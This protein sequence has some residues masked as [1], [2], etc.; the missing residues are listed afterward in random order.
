M[1]HTASVC[2]TGTT[3]STDGSVC[4]T[5]TPSASVSTTGTCSVSPVVASTGTTLYVTGIA[6]SATTARPMPRTMIRGSTMPMA[7]GTSLAGSRA[8]SARLETA[9]R[10]TKAAAARGIAKTRRRPRWGRTQ[11]DLPGDDV[12]LQLREEADGDEQYEGRQPEGSH[13]AAQ[14]HRLSQPGDVEQEQEGDDSDAAHRRVGP[15]LELRPEDAQI[16]RDEGRGDG[17][18]DDAVE[19]KSPGGREPG[20]RPQGAPGEARDP[21]GLGHGGGRLGVGP[22]RDDDHHPDEQQDQ[23]RDAEGVERDAAQDDV[24]GRAHVAVGGA[25]EAAEADLTVTDS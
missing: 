20:E 16:V 6:E 12:G 2:R 15:V 9:S 1:T 25:E 11:R 18:E 8:L 10:P 23:R 24:D 7:L 19:E 4:R 22:R 14:P 3:T 5:K 21:A 13:Q 17:H